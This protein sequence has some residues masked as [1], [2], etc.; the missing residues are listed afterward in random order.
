[1][2]RAQDQFELYRHQRATAERLAAAI[3]AA[4]PEVSAPMCAAVLDYLGAGMPVAEAYSSDL[5]ADAAFWASTATPH[6]LREY[7]GAACRAMVESKTA[8]HI[9]EGPRKRLLVDIWATLSERD[10]AKFLQSVD[11]QG[12]FRGAA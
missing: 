1:M 5:R 10:K 3:D 2:I 6:E 7:V 11:P 9:P 4:P 8:Q 12:A